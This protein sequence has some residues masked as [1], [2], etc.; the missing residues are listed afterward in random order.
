MKGTDL[1]KMVESVVRSSKKGKTKELKAKRRQMTGCSLGST[2]KWDEDEESDGE[3]KDVQEIRLNHE[4]DVV[5]KLQRRSRT[6]AVEGAKPEFPQYEPP[7]INGQEH[8]YDAMNEANGVLPTG[9]STH[10]SHLEYTEKVVNKVKRGRKLSSTQ[11]TKSA[12][13]EGVE[14]AEQDDLDDGALPKPRRRRKSTTTEPKDPA[15]IDATFEEADE[16]DFHP[17][18]D[19]TQAPASELKSK[20]RRGRPEKQDA[21][22]IS[23][24]SK[25]EDP[26]QAEPEPPP[27]TTTKR[28]KTKE[29]PSQERR[30]TPPPTSQPLAESPRKANVA[31][32]TYGSMPPDTPF[33]ASMLVAFR[34]F[35]YFERHEGGSCM[36]SKQ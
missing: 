4:V 31:L 11:K 28:R 16:D 5:P 27:K 32:T 34:L 7:A 20:K 21:D 35:A 3:R 19:L 24:R 26:P 36:K 14:E 22:P 15:I 6:A 23:K 2:N 10:Q 29:T 30:T 18:E 9:Y 25:P 8:D 17:L 1:S 13:L 12:A 33:L